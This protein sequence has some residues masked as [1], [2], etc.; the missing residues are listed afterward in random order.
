MNSFT[1]S[2]DIVVRYRALEG[3]ITE[4]LDALRNALTQSQGLED[5]LD[6]LLQ[7]LIQAEADAHKMD[8]G[9]L[10]VVQKEPLLDNMELQQVSNYLSIVFPTENVKEISLLFWVCLFCFCFVCL[11]AVLFVCVCF[12]ARNFL[13]RYQSFWSNTRL[14][15]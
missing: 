15:T 8:K 11:F 1:C 6:M 12:Q 7:W 2:D 5:N 9:T 13:Q 4:E 3:K 14:A 10:L